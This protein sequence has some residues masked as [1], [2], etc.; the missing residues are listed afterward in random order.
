MYEF[1]YPKIAELSTEKLEA[2][3]AYL[4]VSLENK[5]EQNNS[6]LT[7]FEK[8]NLIKAIEHIRSGINVSINMSDLQDTPFDYNIIDKLL[9]DSKTLNLPLNFYVIGGS[10]FGDNL[11]NQN[12]PMS[13]SQTALDNLV[14]LNN[15]LVD[16]DQY[17]LL[18]MEDATSPEMAWDFEEVLSANN[19][20]D[21]IVEYIKEKK[22]SPFEASAFIHQ[23]ITS[24]FEYKE[25]LLDITSPRSIV[26][27]LNSDDI[28]C[29]GYS[30]LTK[31][32]IDKLNMPGLECSTFTSKLKP[33]EDIIK[34]EKVQEVFKE[35][36]LSM[37]GTG[38]IQNLIKIDDPKYKVKGNYVSDSCWDSKDNS[39]PSGK[40]IGN[41]MFPVEDLL[42]LNGQTF[43]QPNDKVDSMFKSIGL[44]RTY[45]P[46]SLPI[47]SEN[48]NNSKPITVEQY[49][50]CLTN[51]FKTMSP[52]DPPEDIKKRVESVI[53]ISSYITYG[54]FTKDAI[55]SIAKKTHKE[56]Q[57]AIEQA[58][59]TNQANQLG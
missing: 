43:D 11:E 30:Y 38:H 35:L 4:S 58:N 18:F 19:Q 5:L 57:Q 44:K 10:T 55:G 59:Q 39:F 34:N 56:M 53:N 48:I 21:A 6:S 50:K 16:N 2:S 23:Y 27:V 33:N 8:H 20:I 28:V 32:I 51:M 42:H 31:A 9:N 26:G 25:N 47:I 46:Y 29:V 52:N 15:Y 24:Q 13:F 3:I 54:L 40:G 12:I 17:G 36:H 1:R 37:D 41:F 22:F 14:E 7:E 45:D 49:R